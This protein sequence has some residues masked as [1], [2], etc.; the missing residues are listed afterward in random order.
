ML[1]IEN[2]GAKNTQ[3]VDKVMFQDLTIN[4]VPAGRF[5]NAQKC[6]FALANFK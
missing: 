1:N 5:N 3:T 6:H 2:G 4:L